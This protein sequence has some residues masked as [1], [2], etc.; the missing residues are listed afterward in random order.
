MNTNKQETEDTLL[1]ATSA[2]RQLRPPLCR[3]PTEQSSAA[4]DPRTDLQRMRLEHRPALPQSY[5]SP[6]KILTVRELRIQLHV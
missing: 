1:E 3:R 6:T 5:R 2:K 4:V